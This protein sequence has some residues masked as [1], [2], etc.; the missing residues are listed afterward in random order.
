[1]PRHPPA[2]PRALAGWPVSDSFA[3]PDNDADEIVADYFSQGRHWYVLGVD[4]PVEA[5]LALLALGK[6]RRDLR[7]LL[8]WIVL[9]YPCAEFQ[10]VYVRV[11]RNAG[12]AGHAAWFA[13]YPWLKDHLRHDILRLARCRTRPAAN[14]CLIWGRHLGG[15]EA[16]WRTLAWHILRE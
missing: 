3:P 7:Q 5:R 8:D 6:A 13:A 4:L 2:A 10:R 16:A 14:A 15:G 11:A 1:M 12:P 9:R